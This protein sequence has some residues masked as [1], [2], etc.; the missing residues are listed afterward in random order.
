MTR[1][2]S[3]GSSKL[4]AA[5]VALALALVAATFGTPAAQAQADEGTLGLSAGA[6]ATQAD[7]VEYSISLKGVPYDGNYGIFGKPG[8]KLTITAGAQYFDTTVGKYVVAKGATVKWSSVS[9]KLKAVQKGNKLIIKKLPKAGTYK[10]AVAVFDADGKKLAAQKY[11]IVVKKAPT[12]KIR[13]TTTPT[14]TIMLAMRGAK[15]GWDNNTKKPFYIWTVKDLATGKT[16]VWN[17]KKGFVKN[18]G[19]VQGGQV[20]GGGE[21]NLMAAFTKSGTFK[22]TATVYHSNKKIATASTTLKATA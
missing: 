2:I 16:S 7:D 3:K 19:F 21:P 11:T 8:E 18:G 14:G 15:F 5:A 22:I 20:A 10:F 17:S 12:V 13:K 9:A 1:S 4:F 6:L